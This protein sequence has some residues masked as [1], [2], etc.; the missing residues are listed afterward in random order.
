MTQDIFMNTTNDSHEKLVIDAI[1]EAAY[2]ENRPDLVQTAVEIYKKSQSLIESGQ[3]DEGLKFRAAIEACVE[4][5][6]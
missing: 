5:L 1:T 2:E 6:K 4:G 3:R